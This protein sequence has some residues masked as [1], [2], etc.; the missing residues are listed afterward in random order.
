MRAR[1]RVSAAITGAALLAA[2]AVAAAGGGGAP[3]ARFAAT[4]SGYE[5]V[6]AVSTTATGGFVAALT[7]DGVAW[8]LRYTGIEGGA[9]Q[10]AHI[11]LGQRRVNGGVSAFLCSNLPAAP[12]GVQPCPPPPATLTGTIRAAD[13][14]GPAN[15][16]IAPGELAELVRAMRAGVTYAN[17]H[18]AAFPAGEIRGQLVRRR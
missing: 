6:P 18:S 13:V 10:Q 12:A 4:L 8:R 14:V 7:A 2:T 17:V 1:I 15:Q 16:G 9:V 3:S 11:H 5:E